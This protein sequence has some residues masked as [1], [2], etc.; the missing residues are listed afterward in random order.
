M[1]R[2]RHASLSMTGGPGQTAA[3]TMDELGVAFDRVRDPR[4]WQ[5]PILAVIPAA[6]W[7]LVA[8]AVMR[9]T[10]TRPVF[11]EVAEDRDRLLVTAPGCRF[12]DDPWGLLGP[13]LGA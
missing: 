3:F 13:V 1:T 10:A 2:A 11:W 7:R 5:G 8:E 9:F 6:E 12:G 4:D